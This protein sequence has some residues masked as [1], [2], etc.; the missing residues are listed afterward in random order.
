MPIRIKRDGRTVRYGRSYTEFRKAL[1]LMQSGRCMECG[2]MTS[3]TCDILSDWAFHVSHRGTR[4]MSGSVRDDVL[5]PKK[6]QV[7]GGLCA[8]CHR[9]RHVRTI[10]AAAYAQSA[11]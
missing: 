7:E 11:Y 9:E 5:G 10:P 1:Y 3:L 4:G 8:K 2:R 6:G